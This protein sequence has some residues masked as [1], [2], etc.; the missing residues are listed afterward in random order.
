MG[1]KRRNSNRFQSSIWP[2]FVDA[3]TGLLL[4]LMFVLTIFMVVQFVLRE[5]ISGQESELNALS[6]EIELLANALGLSRTTMDSARIVGALTGLQ[7][8]HPFSP[9]DV[10]AVM[11]GTTHFVNALVEA[12]R[13]AP[14]AALRLGLPA[15][16]ALVAIPWPLAAVLF[17]RGAFEAG[18]VPR[19]G[20]RGGVPGLDEE[21]IR[22]GSR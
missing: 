4:V 13:L 12:R 10:D 19:P 18:P 2:G 3:M 15:T 16:A 22:R 21:A 11:I 9:G 14:T 6:D 7:A 8:D 17:G 1:L 20:F 5:Q